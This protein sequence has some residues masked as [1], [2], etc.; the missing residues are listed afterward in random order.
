M[1]S[2]FFN[3]KF[4]F[5]IFVLL[6]PTQL[7]YHFFLNASY[8]YGI[9]I[10]YLAC[11]VYFS[12]FIFILLI[13]LW[14]RNKKNRKYIVSKWK[15]AA[16]F[17]L[18]VL[19]NI[20]IS[21]TQMVSV[22]RFVRVGQYMLLFLYVN[23]SDDLIETIKIPVLIS[24]FYT[25]VLSVAQIVN[26]GSV[27]GV[28]YWIGERGIRQSGTGI[29][30]MDIFG[31]EHLRPYATFPHPNVLAG[32]SLVLFFLFNR[33]NSFYG[34]AVQVLAL[35]L[36]VITYSQNAWLALM[37]TPITVLLILKTKSKIN[38]FVISATVASFFLPIFRAQMNF[39]R[40]I[41][42]RIELNISAGKIISMHP[43]LGVG[44]GAFIKVL[45]TLDLEKSILWLQPVHNAFLLLASEIGIIGLLIFV[46][47]IV[48]NTN[49]YNLAAV[50]CII[51]LSMWDHY[52]VTIHQTA[53]LFAMVLG[54]NNRD[55]NLLRRG[56][57][58]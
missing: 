50:V 44:L 51:L 55:E 56:I 11:V 52:F 20:A 3:H 45:P 36:V 58:R 49:R 29:A 37:A 38:G 4:F 5:Q 28:F 48:R 9:R 15:Y 21:Q 10:D 42:Q 32:F 7:T 40:E 41:L 30:L 14:L 33:V 27:G 19:I 25:F 6:L 35:L 43:A 1:I 26:E 12:D 2:R 22:Y 13:S 47:F 24:L 8:V 23:K 54:Y 18:F 39:P 53:L 46:Y 57:K 16:L 34:K 31:N 17:S